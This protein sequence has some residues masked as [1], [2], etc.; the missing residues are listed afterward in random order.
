MP[1]STP[2]APLLYAQRCRDMTAKY[3]KVNLRFYGLRCRWGLSY[4]DI[5]RALGM[6]HSQV[7]G[8][9][10]GYTAPGPENAVKLAT[11]FGVSIE[12]LFNGR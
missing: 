1:D 11:F 8:I 10:K 4:R 3:P 9:E 6:A 7:Q 2:T 12:E 5:G